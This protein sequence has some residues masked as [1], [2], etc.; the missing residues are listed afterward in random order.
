MRHFHEEL[1]DLK[2][3]VKSMAALV[4]VAVAK[5]ILVLLE[6]NVYAAD[7]VFEKEKKINQLEIDIDDRGHG[8][9]RRGSRRQSGYCA[10]ELASAL[11]FVAILRRTSLQ[12]LH[13]T[14]RQGHVPR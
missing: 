6:K 10:R 9:R 13:L 1:E 11:P 5:A 4:E 12:Q 7:E 8:L 3:L 14:E 2:R